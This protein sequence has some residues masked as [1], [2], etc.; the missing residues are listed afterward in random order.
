MASKKI[1]KIGTQEKCQYVRAPEGP[2]NGPEGA[3]NFRQQ[4]AGGDQDQRYATEC[5]V[6]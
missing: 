5:G 3:Q 2:P 4:A 1:L 6:S